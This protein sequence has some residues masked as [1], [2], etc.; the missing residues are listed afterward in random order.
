[1]STINEQRICCYFILVYSQ[2]I[3]A[4]TGHLQVKY[5]TYTSEVPS[6][7]QRTRCS[8]IVDNTKEQ[9]IRFGVTCCFY[10][11]GKKTSYTSETLALFTGCLSSHSRKQLSPFI[12]S[13]P[14]AGAWWWWWSSNVLFLFWTGIYQLSSV[15][16]ESFMY[17]SLAVTI[18]Y[19]HRL[20]QCGW[21]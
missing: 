1:M 9:R 2:H 13:E 15:Y 18:H 5:I 19:S 16:G 12:F 7:L 3:S 21:F 8:L 17:N 10:C 6:I 4:P 20:P 14:H 11:K